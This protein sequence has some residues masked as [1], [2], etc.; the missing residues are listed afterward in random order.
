MGASAVATPWMAALWEGLQRICPLPEGVEKLAQTTRPFKWNVSIADRE[1]SGAGDATEDIYEHCVDAVFDK[2][3]VATVLVCFRARSLMYIVARALH[4]FFLPAQSNERTTSETHFQDVRLISL[5][6]GEVDWSP[7]DVLMVR[8]RNAAE[9]VTELF[10]LFAEH[11]LRLYE[12]TVV[13]I[14]PFD[15]GEFIS[16]QINI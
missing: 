8:P 13:E 15:D 14:R 6:A 2:P 11:G 12:D 9:K 10:A 1:S 4:V 16:K 3:F 7:G 5:D